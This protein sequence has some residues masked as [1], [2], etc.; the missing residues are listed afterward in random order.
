M[1]YV[2][3][4]TDPDTGSYTADAPVTSAELFA[5]ICRAGRVE[6]P[7]VLFDLDAAGHLDES[8]LAVVLPMIWSWAEF[9]AQ[10]VDQ[11][12]WAAWFERVGYRDARGDMLPRP[13][14]LRLYRGCSPDEQT[15]GWGMSWTDDLDTARQFARRNRG[16]VFTAEVPGY[17]LLSDLTGDP[18]GEHEFIVS[19]MELEAVEPL[20]EELAA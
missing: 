19:G 16:A 18:R 12:A 20:D 11:D 7:V 3:I 1:L 8:T 6:G 2:M 9:P 10:A 15:E 17:L 4:F 5:F 13:E 14:Q